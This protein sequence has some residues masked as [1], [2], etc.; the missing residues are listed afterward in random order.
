MPERAEIGFYLLKQHVADVAYE[1]VRQV[2][3]S[4][5]KVLENI[6]GVNSAV[7]AF[8]ALGGHQLCLS[9][10]RHGQKVPQAFDINASEG[11]GEKEK[12]APKQGVKCPF[13]GWNT[14]FCSAVFLPCL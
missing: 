2:C 8:S 7:T 5:D 6:R 3:F 12:A 9:L 11:T 13:L 10:M 4:V 1:I 14:A